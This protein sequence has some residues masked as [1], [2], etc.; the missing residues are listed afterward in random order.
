MPDLS[1][2]AINDQIRLIC[3]SDRFRGSPQLAALLRALGDDLGRDDGDAAASGQRG[4]QHAGLPSE[5]D[6]GQNPR[7]RVQATRLRQALADYYR[8]P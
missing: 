8:G 2:T 1:R 6:P 7:I 3:D 5:F 4:Q